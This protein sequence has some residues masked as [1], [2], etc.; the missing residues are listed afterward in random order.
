ME[1]VLEGVLS[2]TIL[3]PIEKIKKVTMGV[4]ER[5]LKVMGELG[6]GTI[7]MKG[8]QGIEAWMDGDK[9]ILD[10]YIPILGFLKQNSNFQTKKE[11][12][13][14]ILSQSLDKTKNMEAKVGRAKFLEHKGLGFI[15]P[16]AKSTEIILRFYFES[17]L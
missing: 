2:N 16:G 12:I 17:V 14:Q 1:K 13:N 8:L 7:A 9:S 4:F 5:L 6:I 15:D 11:E 3:K 10:I